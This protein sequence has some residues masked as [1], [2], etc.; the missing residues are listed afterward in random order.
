MQLIFIPSNRKISN[1]TKSGTHSSVI[2]NNYHYWWA[3]D[4]KRST[5]YT[6]VE[7]T[8]KKCSGSITIAQ[9]EVIRSTNHSHNCMTDDQVK[10]L[11]KN[12]E[13]KKKVL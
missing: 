10:I 9:E 3:E 2:Y 11:I 7:K 6:C 8:Y 12:Q 1:P 5:R 13:L 4:N